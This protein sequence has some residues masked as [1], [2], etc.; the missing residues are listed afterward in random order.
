MPRPLSALAHDYPWFHRWM[1]LI[2][3]TAFV[4]GS[5]FFLF[6]D[7]LIPGT[8]IF[9]LASSGMMIDSIGEKLSHRERERRGGHAGPAPRPA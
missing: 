9:I 7:L 6:P 1:G 4:L 8:W 5:I 3:N 2:G